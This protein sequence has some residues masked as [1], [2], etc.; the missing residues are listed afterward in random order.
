MSDA[1]ALLENAAASE[2]EARSAALESDIEI[3]ESRM[4]RAIEAR[5][6]AEQDLGSLTGESE[7]AELD[8]QQTILRMRIEETIRE[9]L[10]K[11]FG[12]ELA[13]EAI[14]R[15]RDKHRSDMLEATERAFSNSQTAH[16]GRYTPSPA[17]HRKSSWRSMPATGQSKSLICRREQGSSCISL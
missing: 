2:I 7:L 13:E 8:E 14:R 10:G 9:Y 15:Y 16:T 12:L 4:D 6:R 1:R 5:T 11:D 17:A 3:A